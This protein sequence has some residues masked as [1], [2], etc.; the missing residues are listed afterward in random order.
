MRQL[1]LLLAITGLLML[2]TGCDSGGDGDTG[3]EEGTL[4]ATIDGTSFAS[5]VATAVRVPFGNG[6][7][8]LTLTATGQDLPPTSLQISLTGFTD[9]ASTYSVTTDGSTAT[10]G[11]PTSTGASTGYS[12]ANAGSSGSVTIDAIS[13]ASV[14]GTFRFTAV[15]ADGAAVEVTDGAFNVRL[16]ETGL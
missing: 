2:C 12:T 15:S 10:V 9:D 6:Q 13:D 8:V 5:T 16:Q 3:L 14:E 11:I 1:S 4:V 7:E